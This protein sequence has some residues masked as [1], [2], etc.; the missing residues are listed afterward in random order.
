[1]AQNTVLNNLPEDEI[2]WADTKRWLGLPWTFTKYKVDNERLTCKKGFLKTETGTNETLGKMDY[3]ILLPR[4]SRSLLEKIN[5]TYETMTRD[6]VPQQLYDRWFVEK[7][8]TTA[9]EQTT[10]DESN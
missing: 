8:Q 7:Q 6:N 1:M 9:E 3:V 2:L 10:Y 4:D 5:E